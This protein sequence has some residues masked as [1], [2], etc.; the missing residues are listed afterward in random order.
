MTVYIDKWAECRLVG[1]FSDGRMVGMFADGRMVGIFAYGR[2]V[3]MFADGRYFDLNCNRK[4]G[5]GMEKSSG[6][7]FPGLGQSEH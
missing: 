4:P 7:A 3:G 5:T 1:M 6:S 2:M